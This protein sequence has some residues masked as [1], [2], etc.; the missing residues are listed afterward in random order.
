MIDRKTP[1]DVRVVLFGG[2]R[3]YLAR[4]LNGNRRTFTNLDIGDIAEPF[5]PTIQH[6]MEQPIERERLVQ[7]GEAISVI[8]PFSLEYTDP[9][10]TTATIADVLAKGEMYVCACYDSRSA[11]ITAG[12]KQKELL[13]LLQRIKQ[14]IGNGSSIL[15]IKELERLQTKILRLFRLKL[16][17]LF[18]IDG[19]ILSAM[20]EKFPQ[21]GTTIPSQKAQIVLVNI[22]LADKGLITRAELTRITNEITEACQQEIDLMGMSLEK[23]IESPADLANFVDK[24]LRLVD[25][26]NF[27]VN[28]QPFAIVGTFEKI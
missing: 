23:K 26:E 21:G 8:T 11:G 1:S 19:S 10:L 13:P 22:A 20:R 15:P 4:L 16:P 27:Q 6:D 2:G 17:N 18:I 28:G 3:G 5:I 12:R 14:F 25:G 24:G 9:R 7:N